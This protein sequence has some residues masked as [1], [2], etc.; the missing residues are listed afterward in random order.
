MSRWLLVRTE[1]SDSGMGERFPDSGYALKGREA[2]EGMHAKN[3][4]IRHNNTTF[5][6]YS[7]Q[8]SLRTQSYVVLL[9]HRGC[10]LPM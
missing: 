10:R 3:E 4:Q 7:K 5:C 1:K 9:G 2:I 6:Y 8:Y